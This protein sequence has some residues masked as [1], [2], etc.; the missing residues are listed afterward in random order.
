MGFG[1]ATR[2]GVVLPQV[3]ITDPSLEALAT[4]VRGVEELGFVHVLAYDHV[5]GVDRSRHSD[6]TG[7]Y[8]HRDPFL[9]PLVL[10]GALLAVSSLELVTGVLVLPQRSAALVAKQTATLDAMAPG[11]MRL[12]VGVGWNRPEH[13]GLGTDFATRGRRLDGQVH[14]L[15]RLWNEESID[16]SGE[17]DRIDGAGIC[18]RPR[19]GRIPVWFG[20]GRVSTQQGPVP[21][22]L[23][24]IGR[25]GDGFI[26]TLRPGAELRHAMNVITMTAIEFGRDPGEIGLE[27]QIGGGLIAAQTNRQIDKWE[28]FGATH[29]SVSTLNQG[30]SWPY[31]H[32]DALERT[33]GALG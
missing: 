17:F 25:L 2:V 26:T 3:E 7:V 13:E 20:A 1:R 15:Q 10:F 18:P 12:G 21:R 30:L 22:A 11:R 27:G 4:F 14:L 28:L 33:A 6:F 9:E 29:V 24:R 19:A 23:R 31:G 16:F 8:D 32:L 5:L